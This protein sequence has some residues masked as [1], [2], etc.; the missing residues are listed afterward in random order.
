[1]Q[2]TDFSSTIKKISGH[3]KIWKVHKITGEKELV[4]DQP[5]MVLYGGAKVLAYALSGNENAKI[6][7]MYLGFNNSGSF[8]PPT[9][10]AA[11]SAPFSNF[12]APFGYVREPLAFAPSF[13]SDTNYEDNTT[14][15]TTMLTA[16][17]SEHGASLS[18]GT[19]RLYEVALVAALDPTSS[20][21][22]VVFARTNFNPITYENNFNFIVS[23]GVK[24]LV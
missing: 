21:S 8:T 22:D 18:S 4:V 16:A 12:S 17:S 7:G 15:F 2:D 11:Y 13:L 5:N 19:S 14:I 6:W 1:M 20:N 10:D 24:F 9:I 3:V 23:W